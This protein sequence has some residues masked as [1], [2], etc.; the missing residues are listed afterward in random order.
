MRPELL[1]VLVEQ[2]AR[3][4]GD[5][6][7]RRRGH[8]V[9][10]AQPAETAADQDPVDRRGRPPEQRPEAIGAVSPVG[11]GREDLG[12]GGRAQPARRAVRPGGPVEE[13]RLALGA[14]SPDPLVRGRPADPELLGDVRGRPAGLHAGDEELTT[15]DGQ[16]RPRMCHESLLLGL[17]LNTPNPA[18]G[19]SSV[20]NVCGDYT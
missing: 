14:V 20:N 16:A 4:A 1:V 8:P 15:E 19:L 6:A 3:V 5:V 12:L 13:A 7:D 17:V 2:G 10:V 9:G 18:A 11:A